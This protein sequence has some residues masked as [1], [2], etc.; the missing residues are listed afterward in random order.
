MRLYLISYLLQRD[1]LPWTRGERRSSRVIDRIELDPQA[2][3][4]DSGDAQGA[5]SDA[6]YRDRQAARIAV[7][8]AHDFLHSKRACAVGVGLQ[9][10]RA[11]LA[12]DD[13][14]R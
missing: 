4:D 7:R 6:A 12:S 5:G 14:E 8:A 13:R 2:G 1:F 3:R 11:A 9:E 10:Q